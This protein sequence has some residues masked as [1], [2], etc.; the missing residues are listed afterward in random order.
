M[1]RTARK[2]YNIK[3]NLIRYLTEEK[4]SVYRLEKRCGFSNGYLRNVDYRLPVERVETILDV[5]QDLNR[6]WLLSSKGEM[7]NGLPFWEFSKKP[8]SYR[9]NP[10]TATEICTQIGQLYGQLQRKEQVSVLVEAYKSLS[11]TQ[12]NQFLNMV[13]YKPQFEKL[14]ADVLAAIRKA[15]AEKGKD[16][17]IYAGDVDGLNVVIEVDE[18]D[19]D[20]SMRLYKIINNPFETVF[21]IKNRYAEDKIS[22]S[23]VATGILCDIADR[24]EE[25]L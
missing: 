6:E 11:N 25:N 7:R 2:I 19:P 24:L 18:R 9:K 14:H 12:K 16:G 21:I 13:I 15:V 5:L 22:A 1:A 23:E 17:V 4:I 8:D 3:E 20:N 10:L